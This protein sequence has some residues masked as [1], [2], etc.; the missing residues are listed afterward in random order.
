MFG[1]SDEELEEEDDDDEEAE[2]W[3]HLEKRAKRADAKAAKKKATP[4]SVMKKK[5]KFD[6]YSDDEE[7]EEDEEDVSTD[8]EEMPKIQLKLKSPTVTKA[9]TTKKG[10]ASKPAPKVAKTSAKKFESDEDLDELAE[11]SA[12]T[13]TA[14]KKST[15]KNVPVDTD[16]VYEF[17]T[18]NI[19]IRDLQKSY[20]VP[21][22]HIFTALAQ[23]DFKL[24]VM[25]PQDN[26]NSSLVLPQGLK[27]VDIKTKPNEISLVFKYG[28]KDQMTLQQ[29]S[30]FSELH[31]KIS[32]VKYP[33]PQQYLEDMLNY[34]CYLMPQNRALL[35]VFVYVYLPFYCNIGVKAD[36]SVDFPYLEKKFLQSD[37]LTLISLDTPIMNLMKDEP[38]MET[39]SVVSLDRQ[40]VDLV[41]SYYQA[42]YKKHPRVWEMQRDPQQKLKATPLPK[43][44]KTKI[45]KFY[46]N[47]PTSGTPKGTAKSKSPAKSEQFSDNLLANV[48][49][50]PY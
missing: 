21:S 47:K 17:K 14:A 35:Y 18:L 13:P 48:L 42:I 6:S 26:N 1:G 24:V 37:A 40:L 32:S 22:K 15:R 3:D 50:P 28:S 27:A 49:F 33:F 41:T 8:E 9:Q 5:S 19:F 7:D 4:G 29:L 2:T 23:D 46:A 16:S 12:K 34:Y 25:K 38:K 36:G 39:Q 11:E 30:H 20:L 43:K 45:D 44:E 31:Q 10:K